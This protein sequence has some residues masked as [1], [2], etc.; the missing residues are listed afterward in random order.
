M[1]GPPPANRQDGLGVR[2]KLLSPVLEVSKNFTPSDPPKDPKFLNLLNSLDFVI[3]LAFG[4]FF[5]SYFCGRYQ[6][7]L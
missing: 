7:I 6:T 5:A 1:T 3:W 2:P 4:T